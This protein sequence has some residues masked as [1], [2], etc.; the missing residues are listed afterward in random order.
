M[1][2]SVLFL[3]SLFALSS[4]AQ[5]VQVVNEVYYDPEI[6]PPVQG[7]PANHRTYRIYAKLQDPTDF[8]SAIYA[9]AGCHSLHVN[10][11]DQ[12]W[13][14]SF[15]GT[16]GDVINAGFCAF[17]PTLC[18]DSF[19][20]IGRENSSSP[21][22]SVGIIASCPAANAWDSALGIGLDLNVCDGAVYALNG[23][24]NG[25]GVGP[26]NRVLLFQL[27]VPN[28][29]Y[30]TY[31]LNLAV[32]DEGIGGNLISYVWDAENVGCGSPTEVDGSGLGLIGGAAGCSDPDAD[33]YNPF[34]EPGGYCQYI[35]CIDAL[36]VNY[37][38]NANFDN[39]LCVY[40]PSDAVECALALG[41][42]MD[43]PEIL[44]SNFGG[45]NSGTA[46]SCWTDQ[47]INNGIWLQF[48]STDSE[49]IINFA[50]TEQSLDIAVF[51]AC[52]G[53]E[54]YCNEAIQGNGYYYISGLSAASQYFVFIDS[55]SQGAFQLN[56]LSG[57][58]G[59]NDS[60][61]D[62]YDAGSSLDDGTCQYL[63]CTSPQACNYDPD[64]NADDGNCETYTTLTAIVYADL[65]GNEYFDFDF[66]DDAPLS[67]K[68]ILVE[69]TGEIIFSDNFGL[70]QYQV[71]AG[72]TYTFTLLDNDD[73][74]E[75]LENSIG[76]EINASNNCGNQTLHLGFSV[77]NGQIAS[78]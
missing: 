65:D 43:G 71:P 38:L 4:D 73:I 52:G 24:I 17:I 9:V 70:F 58:P 5:L 6:G 16:T 56:I 37:D 72:S 1:R 12:I 32:F 67:N 15:G 46:G 61:A 20:T 50:A 74:Y 8:V 28:S 54:I 68:Q 63:G 40:V 26:Q 66:F 77:Q 59:C 36:A 35:G 69:E 19:V 2:F 11:M 18:Y 78:V 57:H 44:T 39:G 13:N 22:S 62:N 23:D 33:N 42:I 51:D 48:E 76:V 29:S 14:S 34:L 55:E 25:F 3:I 47:V 49:G 21:G 60:E 41:I 27:T 30:F 53:S 75:P 10:A 45:G 31:Y 7:Y 64:A